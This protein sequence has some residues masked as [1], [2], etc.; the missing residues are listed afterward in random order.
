M[1]GTIAI[2]RLGAGDVAGGRALNAL[3]ADV[4][5]DPGTY[6]ETPPSDAC[7]AARLGRPTVFALV[8]ET[9]GVVVGGLTAYALEK[10]E[11]E[12][13]EIYI[14]DL[15][16]AETHRRRGVATALIERLR[17][18]AVEAGA[19]VMFVQAD[20][21]DDPAIALYTKLGVREDVMHF[22][23]EAPKPGG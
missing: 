16:V 3:F 21:G 2:R 9:D 6:A 8:A 23:I 13:S 1:S 12:R 20:H 22:D 7:L 18:L 19:W 4:F 10:L 15:A 11:S 17:A 5:G 14:Y